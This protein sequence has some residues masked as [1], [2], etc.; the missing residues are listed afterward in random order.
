MEKYAN[1]NA[2]ASSSFHPAHVAWGTHKRCVLG[3][4]KNGR[5]DIETNGAKCVH[6]FVRGK[7]L[8]SDE[9]FTHDKDAADHAL[10]VILRRADQGII[11]PYN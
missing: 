1:R 2:Y 5:N 6:K 10:P 3:E 8:F 7:T 4:Y 9:V 11:L